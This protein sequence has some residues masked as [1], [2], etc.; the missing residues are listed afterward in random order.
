MRLF[1]RRGSTL[2]QLVLIMARMNFNTPQDVLLLFA[3]DAM[4]AIQLQM[5]PRKKSLQI[6]S[7]RLFL[8]SAFAANIYHLWAVRWSQNDK[9][10]TIWKHQVQIAEYR[11]HNLSVL[12]ISASDPTRIVLAFFASLKVH[13]TERPTA[14]LRNG[15]S[16]RISPA[17]LW[18]P[19]RLAISWLILLALLSLSGSQR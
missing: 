18:C 2:R 7:R 1:E 8:P 12:E 17:L 19:L 11:G 14:G 13:R 15:R 3:L 9:W 5:F 4:G 6:N 16:I 10:Q